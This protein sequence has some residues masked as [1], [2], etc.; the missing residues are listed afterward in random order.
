MSLSL[1]PHGFETWLPALLPALMIIGVRVIDPLVVSG[2]RILPLL[3]LVTLAVHNWFAGV[4]FFALADKD[5]NVARGDPV[6]AVAGAGDVLVVGQNWAFERYLNYEGE[7]KTYLISR[8]G[9]EGLDELAEAT[10]SGGG[11][12]FLF[13]DVFVEF[14]DAVEGLRATVDQT[15]DD[16]RID[17]GELGY[18]VIVE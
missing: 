4:G 6:L 5:Y 8:Q 3:T 15:A 1:H 16:R 14:P 12:I 17:L 2:W 9:R 7:A 11:R 10:L 13:D 18:A